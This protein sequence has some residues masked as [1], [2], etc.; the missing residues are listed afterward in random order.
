MQCTVCVIVVLFQ[1]RHLY[2]R[3]RSLEERQWN[4]QG[5]RNSHKLDGAG[6]NKTGFV[7]CTGQPSLHILTQ[8][9]M[10]QCWGIEQTIMTVC[11]SVYVHVQ[12]ICVTECML[13]HACTSLLLC[14]CLKCLYIWECGFASGSHICP[15]QNNVSQIKIRSTAPIALFPSPCFSLSPPKDCFILSLLLLHSLQLSLAISWHILL[16]RSSS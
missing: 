15:N 2:G 1:S 10:Y 4:E 12:C 13:K 16:S 5:L 6:C 3:S 7:S 11:V 9:H 14:D 8:T